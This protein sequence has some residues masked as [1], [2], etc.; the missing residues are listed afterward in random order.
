[1]NI[2][3]NDQYARVLNDTIEFRIIIIII[4]INNKNQKYTT[5]LLYI[6]SKRIIESIIFNKIKYDYYINLRFWKLIYLINDY[7][8][9]Y[10]NTFGVK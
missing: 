6:I 5:E 7:I 4:I 8:E 10:L 1:M 9:S 3:I 2:I